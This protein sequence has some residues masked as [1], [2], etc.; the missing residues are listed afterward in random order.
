MA[1]TRG[2]TT[3]RRLRLL[4]R[5]PDTAKPTLADL[6]VPT[7][8][9]GTPFRPGELPRPVFVDLTDRARSIINVEARRRCAPAEL[10]VRVT[11]EAA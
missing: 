11:V 6:S 2:A 9:W 3:Q 7:R 10:A 5:C 4:P 1:T 8:A